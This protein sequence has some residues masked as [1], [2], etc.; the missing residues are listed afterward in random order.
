MPSTIACDRVY[1]KRNCCAQ[2][3]ECREAWEFLAN[4]RLM[5][6]DL[7][8]T[9][10]FAPQAEDA[11]LARED[12][13]KRM[14]ESPV[15]TW[16][17]FHG[18]ELAVGAMRDF[19]D[20]QVV[21]DASGNTQKLPILQLSHDDLCFVTAWWGLPN[22]CTVMARRHDIRDF[23]L[24]TFTWKASA[25]CHKPL[26]FEDVQLERYGH[27]LGPF[28][29]PLATAAHFFGNV[30]LLPYNTGVYPP[31]ECRYPLGHYRPG[32]CAP[33]LIPAFPLSER[34]AK[35]QL[36]G[37]LGLWGFAS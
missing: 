2:D 30:F 12:E 27:S 14:S 28:L 37:I 10:P 31:Y 23:R 8:I 15:R 5:D 26:Y 29:Q 35:A 11:E 7:D 9:P 17:D 20:G 33:W 4:R 21:V 22:E 1:D 25:L 32:S 6:I 3:Y 36:I 13:A 18:R 34:G 19:R 24:C 16:R